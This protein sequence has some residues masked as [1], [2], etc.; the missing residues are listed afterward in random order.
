MCLNIDERI[1]VLPNKDGKIEAYKVFRRLPS[2]RITSVYHRR[3]YWKHGLNRSNRKSTDRT[4]DEQFKIS[5]GYHVFRNKK[6]AQ[7]L[8]EQRKSS[9]R[10]SPIVYFVRKVWI[11]P[12]DVIAMGLFWGRV[13]IA[14]TKLY[15][16]FD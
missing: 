3:T 12:K 4:Y 2:G 10:G 14:C 5:L 6:D 15:V 7:Y 11:D 9:N 16:R 1:V 13:S 8:F